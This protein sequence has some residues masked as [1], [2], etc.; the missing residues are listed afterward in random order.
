[1]YILVTL[2]LIIIASATIVSV[3]ANSSNINDINDREPRRSHHIIVCYVI[4]YDII[5]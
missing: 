5:L 1:M 2:I 3:N 4:L